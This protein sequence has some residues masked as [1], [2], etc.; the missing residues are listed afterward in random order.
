MTKIKSSLLKSLLYIFF[1]FIIRKKFLVGYSSKFD[2]RMKFKTEDGGG[3]EIYKKSTYEDDNSTFLVKHLQLNPGDTFL[4]IGSNIG[5]YAI[6]L[7]KNFPGIQTYA[8]E[9]DQVNIDCFLYNIKINDTENVNLLKKGVS[10]ISGHK[11]MY[12]YKNSNKGRNNFGT[13]EIEVISVDDFVKEKQLKRVRF[14]KIDIE[15]Y[16]YYALKGALYTLEATELLLMEFA[17]NYMRKGNVN[18]DDVLALLVKQKFKPYVLKN[19]ILNYY[20]ITQLSNRETNID[21][22]LLKEDQQLIHSSLII[23]K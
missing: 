20:P 11:T 9:P 8:F 23:N 3:R 22:Y 13:I 7:N 14:I 5:W 19:G 2:L 12:I 15:G 6:L 10:E 4:D 21:L 1:R 17:P 18:P 16:E